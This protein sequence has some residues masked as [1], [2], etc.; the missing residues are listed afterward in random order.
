[1]SKQIKIKLREGEV[2]GHKITAL[3]FATLFN[4][5]LDDD[6]KGAFISEAQIEAAGGECGTLGWYVCSGTGSY[7]QEYDIVE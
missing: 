7:P 6:G 3:N 2:V 4:A 5:V 1:M